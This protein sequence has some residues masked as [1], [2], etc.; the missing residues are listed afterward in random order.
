MQGDGLGG[1]DAWFDLRAAC[2]KS[3]RLAEMIAAGPEFEDFGGGGAVGAMAGNVIRKWRR[4]KSCCLIRNPLWAIHLY[5]AF[6]G[7]APGANGF[8]A[9]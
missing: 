1:R 3:Y 8:A 2:R 5:G 9:K 7:T 4:W 6:A